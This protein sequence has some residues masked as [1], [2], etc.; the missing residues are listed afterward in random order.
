M[1]NRC[2]HAFIKSATMY[3][4]PLN[5]VSRAMAQTSAFTRLVCDFA[6]A[7]RVQTHNRCRYSSQP[8]L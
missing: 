8:L 4:F 1:K 5:A 3:N 6:A 7:P 2:L